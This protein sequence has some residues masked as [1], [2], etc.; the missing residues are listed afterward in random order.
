M[1]KCRE[2]L[3]ENS[4]PL[5]LSLFWL[6]GLIL[7]VQT[8]HVAGQAFLSLMRLGVTGKV[9]I[10]SLISCNIL[11]FLLIALAIGASKLWLVCTLFMGE[12]FRLSFLAFALFR[13]FGSAGWLVHLLFRFS[14]LLLVPLYWWFTVSSC[15]GDSHS[16]GSLLLCIV[17]VVL[18][19]CL[20]YFVICPL[21]GAIIDV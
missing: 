5:W 21:L 17:M 13:C 16:N 8:A 4:T 19:C 6:F 14:G 12:A 2:F 1:G 11:P 9:S 18:I 3:R 10:V 15:K 7:G 20:D